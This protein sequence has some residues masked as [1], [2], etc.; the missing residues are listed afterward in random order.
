MPRNGKS[1]AQALLEEL[2]GV[3][4][5]FIMD[6]EF[7]AFEF[8]DKDQTTAPAGKYE[9][10]TRDGDDPNLILIK[11]IETEELFL[12]DSSLQNFDRFR[13]ST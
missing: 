6:K 2:G 10:I 11:N 3:Q 1:K 5:T 12:I 7:M 8:L 4:T 13:R 9:A